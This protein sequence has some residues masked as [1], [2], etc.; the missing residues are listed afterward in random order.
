MA[1]VTQ[2]DPR[3]KQK[4]PQ[5]LECQSHLQ[6]QFYRTVFRNSFYL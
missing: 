6:T 5:W 1:R 2:F 3:A 4:D